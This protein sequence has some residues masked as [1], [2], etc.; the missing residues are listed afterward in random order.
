[1]ARKAFPA[2]RMAPS[3][4]P[5]AAL[6]RSQ[7]PTPP[8]CPGSP[9]CDPATAADA[10]TTSTATSL[11]PG[12]APATCDYVF[13]TTA[14]DVTFRAYRA[15]SP[16]GADRLHT[17]VRH[18]YY[19]GSALY[20]VLPGFVA[21]FGVAA[22]PSLARVYDYRENHPGAI[23]EDE[24][25]IINPDGPGNDK[26]WL[27]Y[28]SAYDD[29]KSPPRAVNR[30]A[31]L[32]VNLVDNRETLDEKGFASFARVVRG[33]EVIDKWFAGYGEMREACDLHPDGGWVCEGP[34]ETDL[35]ARGVEAYVDEHFPKLDRIGYVTATPDPTDP[36]P[37]WY[38]GN[39]KHHF[40]WSEGGEGH[41]VLFY[42]IFSLTLLMF[43]L[44][45][46]RQKTVSSKE[47]RLS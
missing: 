24:P 28:S 31:E 27:S 35:Y 20:R 40:S 36:D 25:A 15:L 22:D 3:A 19:D 4:A 23:L 29:T 8:S 43:F 17:L 5:A 46:R 11:V 16:K 2:P 44:L 12:R 33:S 34:S 10:A 42:V 13:H 9:L 41:G 6:P 37:G 7:W 26:L 18:G 1:V 32:F 21:Q 39:S 30:T 47:R 45:I 38:Y 14:G